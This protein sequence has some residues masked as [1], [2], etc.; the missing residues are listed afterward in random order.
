MTG[1][2]IY[3]R[4]AALYSTY[5]SLLQTLRLNLGGDVLYSL[6]EKAEALGKKLSLKEAN[7]TMLDG[8]INEA[9]VIFV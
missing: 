1:L 7:P 2:E 4:D 8:D 6:L 3:N 5:A 9:A